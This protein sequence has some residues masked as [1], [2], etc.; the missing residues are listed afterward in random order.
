MAQTA[1]R[2][3]AADLAIVRALLAAKPGG[4]EAFV[5][6]VQSDIY[7]ACRL[8]SPPAEADDTF[9][10][11]LAQLRAN[12]FARLAKFDGRATLASYLRLEVRDL[13]AQRVTRLFAVDRNRA[14]Q[15]FEHFFKADILRISARYFRALPG[16]GELDEDRYHEIASH[17]IED[18][19]RRILAYDG[20]GSFGGYVLGVVRNLCIDLLRRDLPRRRLPAAVK[21]LPKLEQEVFRQL[22]WENCPRDRLPAALAAR[23]GEAVAPDAVARAVSAVMAVL[24]PGFG[25]EPERPRMVSLS[26]AA[27]D[28]GDAGELVDDRDS[29][30]DDMI[31]REKETAL[32][33][34]SEALRAAVSAL[35]T[36]IR[37]YLQHVMA[38]EPPLAPRDIA[39]LMAR[40]VGEIYKLRQQAERLLLRALGD[41]EII[42]K[43]RLSV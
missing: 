15:V 29:P 28:A 14:W 22:Y 39:R 38:H 43:W 21:R 27:E 9:L 34:A 10:E 36:D 7:T 1:P 12:N 20:H 6:H 26:A 3:G 5:R 18:G 24:P 16:S 4:W 37:L 8:V 31:A 25:A 30:E 42:R 13:L 23:M 33:E 32:E 35:P 19:Y 41:D 2:R 40:P 11:I 17:L